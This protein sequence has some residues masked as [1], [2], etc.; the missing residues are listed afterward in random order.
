MKL[1]IKLLLPEI[2]NFRGGALIQ[3]VLFFKFLQYVQTFLLV[4]DGDGTITTKELG[5]VMRSLG[6]NPTEAELQVTTY[7]YIYIC[8]L[9]SISIA[10]CLFC[11]WML[12][13]HW[14]KMFI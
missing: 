9:R 11:L 7:I 5:T 12:I 13:F 10:T 8:V 2:V 14:F 1:N 3:G 4:Q 6:Q